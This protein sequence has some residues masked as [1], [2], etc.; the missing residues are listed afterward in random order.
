[1]G[2][3]TLVKGQV[4][5]D[6]IVQGTHNDPRCPVFSDFF[7]GNSKELFEIVVVIG[8]HG[9]CQPHIVGDRLAA[10]AEFLEFMRALF[11]MDTYAFGFKVLKMSVS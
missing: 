1:M 8:L 7:K 3:Q 2:I 6:D 9:D 5:F 10:E 11:V 4:F